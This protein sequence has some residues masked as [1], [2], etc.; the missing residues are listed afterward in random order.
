MSNSSVFGNVSRERYEEIDKERSRSQYLQPGNIPDNQSFRLRQV[1]VGAG[2]MQGWL[3]EGVRTDGVKVV[4][5]GIDDP[6]PD[7]GADDWDAGQYKNAHG[8]V[9]SI[10]V[11][12]YD[13]EM[14]QILQVTQASIQSALMDLESDHGDLRAFDFTLKKEVGKGGRTSYHVSACPTSRDPS[15]F[16][17][18]VKGQPCDVS[19]LVNNGDPFDA[20]KGAQSIDLSFF[21]VTDTAPAPAPALQQ[22]AQPVAQPAPTQPPVTDTKVP[23]SVGAWTQFT[24]QAGTRLGDAPKETIL[25]YEQK[26][27]EAG[28][29]SGE[30]YANLKAAA[31][32]WNSQG[33]AALGF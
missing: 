16:I 29:T 31:D 8:L 1:G 20:E 28:N 11:W 12:N 13:L 30:A 10:P 7:Y 33:A 26:L 19:V 2:Y 21:G 15:T 25:E 6:I 14:L 22:S 23:A 24:T 18:R 27:R 3:K 17:D 32:Y 9:G 5:W 4:R